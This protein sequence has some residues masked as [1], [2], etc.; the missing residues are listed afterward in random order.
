[1]EFDKWETVELMI[2]L[3]TQ[4]GKIYSMF[5]EQF[6][7]DRDFWARLAEEEMEHASLLRTHLEFLVE[8]KPVFDSLAPEKKETFLAVHRRITAI[9]AEIKTVQVTRMDAHSVALQIEQSAGE[10]HFQETIERDDPRV[11]VA[12]FAN[13]ASA[14]KDHARRIQEHMG[15]IAADSSRAGGIAL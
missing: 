1:M 4:V 10:A 5:A 14:D 12:V 11:P 9:L 7:E 13:L 6:C 8:S 3:E 2:D 15:S